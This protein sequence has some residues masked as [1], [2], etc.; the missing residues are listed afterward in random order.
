MAHRCMDPF[1]G[2]VN[3]DDKNIVDVSTVRWCNGG[4][5]YSAD[6]V[7]RINISIYDF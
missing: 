4:G 6:P 2:D 5:L 3:R 7:M 1:H